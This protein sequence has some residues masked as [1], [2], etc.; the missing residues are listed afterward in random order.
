MQTVMIPITQITVNPE[1]QHLFPPLTESEF[2]SLRTD[3]A[4]VGILQ[5]LNVERM[6]SKA[7][8]RYVVLSGHHRLKVAA[9]L[10]I[11]ELPCSI[12]STVEEKISA[13][14]DN[15][16][17][18]QLSQT[19]R[20]GLLKEERKLRDAAF[21]KLIPGLQ[22]IM[23]LL[24]HEVRLRVTQMSAEDQDEYLCKFVE[25]AEI[26]KGRRG[27]LLE[28]RGPQMD[29][30]VTKALSATPA[31]ES[32][33]LA[34][35]EQ[36]IKDLEDNK[37]SEL[38]QAHIA[39]VALSQK[40]KDA[41]S[42]A[43]RLQEEI[44]SL[45]HQVKNQEAEAKAAILYADEKLRQPSTA[46]EPSAPDALLNGLDCACRLMQGLTTFALKSPILTSPH[47]ELARKH[48]TSLSKAIAQIEESFDPHHDGHVNGT[49][50][51][52]LA[53]H[54]EQPTLQLVGQNGNGKSTTRHKK[55][56]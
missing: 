43:E 36:R 55:E 39:Q 51:K 53:H 33:A 18:R 22:D 3:I 14:F 46:N 56:A 48:L 13:I 20:D 16:H 34:E 21:S 52:K 42:E 23:H 6:P 12:I 41:R 25:G 49:H 11:P 38:H 45:R 9:K 5:A 47:Q 24:P 28:A 30:T 37:K 17:R 40:L 4:R 35:L 15:A 26:V 54:L 1:Y 50:A 8:K 44:E 2:E 32:A 7:D 19:V 29:R 31:A 27:R 10:G